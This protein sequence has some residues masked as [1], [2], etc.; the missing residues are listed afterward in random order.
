LYQTSNAYQSAINRLDRYTRVRLS[1]GEKIYTDEAELK[2]LTL[3]TGGAEKV[4]GNAYSAK[5]TAE[6]Q[7]TEETNIPALGAE[8]CAVFWP[9]GQNADTVPTAPVVLESVDYDTDA[10]TCTLSG[11]DRM[12][13]L[14]E[15]TAAEI[16]I[17]YPTTIGAYAAAAATL[18]GLAPAGVDWRQC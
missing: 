8:M 14:A 15:H 11:Y 1:A 17:T 13:R 12:V 6:L 4:I 2:T 18:A 16:D 9:D 5:L 7:L 10:G 3:E